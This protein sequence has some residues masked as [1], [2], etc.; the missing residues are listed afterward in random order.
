M[1]CENSTDSTKTLRILYEI[2]TSS[3]DFLRRLIHSRSTKIVRS[4]II[5]RLKVIEDAGSLCV[6]G[7]LIDIDTAHVLQTV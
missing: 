7:V 2:S 1:E 4:E 3:A 5:F 6:G